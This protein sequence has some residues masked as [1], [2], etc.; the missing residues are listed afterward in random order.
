MEYNETI[1]NFEGPLDLLLHLIKQVKQDDVNIFDINIAELTEKYLEYIDN[2]KSLNLNV[3]SEYLVMA[4]TLMEIKSRELLPHSEEEEEDDPKDELINRLQEYQ[5]YKE[6]RGT[7]KEYALER[8]EM[9]SKVPS[10]LEEFH[11]DNVKINDN[12]TLD[13]LINAFLKFQQKKELEKPLNT[14]ITS[15]EY[16][17]EEIGNKIIKRLKKNKSFK[18]EDLFEEKNRSYVVATFLTI[19]DLTRKGKLLLKQDY[20]LGEIFLSLRDDEV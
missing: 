5:R 15:K 7:F 16:S 17:F 8:K 6:I 20:N 2:M 9:F 14:V 12:V 19:L 3:D 10:M 1:D 13:D 11:D 18:F 4:A